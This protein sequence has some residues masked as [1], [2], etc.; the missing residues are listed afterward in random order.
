M[1]GSI[2][3]Q[4]EAC[5]RGVQGAA[6]V[7]AE[8]WP[9]QAP[10]MSRFENRRRICKEKAVNH[11]NRAPTCG[12]GDARKWV[13][14]KRCRKIGW[15]CGHSPVYVIWKWGTRKDGSTRAH[16]IEEVV[17]HVSGLQHEMVAQRSAAEE[18]RQH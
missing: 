7:C 17:E 4:T 16:V 15:V 8:E 3:Q 12:P 18:H 5:G 10:W 2:K 6:V 1:E 11:K 14:N 9:G 13:F